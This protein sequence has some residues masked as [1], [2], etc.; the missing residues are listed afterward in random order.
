MARNDNGGS[1]ITGFL[2]GG[3][4]GAVVG[5]LLALDSE[6]GRFNSWPALLKSI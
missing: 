4:I 1:F 5:I 2:L 3:I 6:M